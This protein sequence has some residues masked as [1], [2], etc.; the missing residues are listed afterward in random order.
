M[1]EIC[2]FINNAKDMEHQQRQQHTRVANRIPN[3][4]LLLDFERAFDTLN[5]SLLIQKLIETNI[6]TSLINSMV[7]LLSGA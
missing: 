1:I 5:R 2:N 3:Y 6:D 7:D 4:I